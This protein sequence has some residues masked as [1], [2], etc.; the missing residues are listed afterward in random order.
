MEETMQTKHAVERLSFRDSDHTY[1]LEGKHIPSVTTILGNLSKP[2]LVWWSAKVGAE[3]VK[4][5]WEEHALINLVERLKVAQVDEEDI[6]TLYNL[7]RY[8]HSK[9]LQKAATKGS[10][11]HNAVEQFHEDF[12]NAERPTDE[13]AA[14]AFDAFVEWW[15][16]HGFTM[17]STERKIVGRNNDYAGRMDLL[18]R[19]EDGD[20]YVCDMKT[21]N[22]IYLESIV[23]NAAYA[24][25]VEAEMGEPIVGT[26]VLWLPEH[27]DK[28][29]VVERDREEW[30]L[31]FKMCFEPLLQLHKYRV[32]MNAWTTEINKANKIEETKA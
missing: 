5:W 29:I 23:Q 25:A 8:Q 7:A 22:G 17:V 13:R 14:I 16:E 15:S 32:G 26:K 21:S 27:L 24:D 4:E 11:V 31:D 1:Y 9:K 10:L 3:A 6:E 30:Q 18:C 28:M 19:S 12:F 2:G 20:L